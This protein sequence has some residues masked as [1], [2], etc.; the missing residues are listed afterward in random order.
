MVEAE[1]KIRILQS[2]GAMNHGGIEHFVMNLYRAID[3]DKIQFDFMYRV[4]EPCVFDEEI[5]DLGGIIYRCPSPDRHPLR[6][7]KY[8]SAFFAEHPEYKV[9]HE[10]RTANSGFYGL[11][12][13]ARRSC[14]QTRIVHSHSSMSLRRHGTM[15]NM[16]ELA[17][18]RV[19]TPRIGEIATDYIACSDAA[20][21]W[22]FPETVIDRGKVVI[23]PNGIRVDNFAYNRSNRALVRKKFEIP[24]GALVIGHVGRFQKVKNHAFLVELL[25]F[26]I[27]GGN[28]AYLLL[29][30]DGDLRSDIEERALSCGLAD[31]VV[32]AGPQSNPSPFYSAMDVFCMPSLHEGLPVSC[33]E[34]QASGLPLVLSDVISKQ[35]DL[36]GRVDF[37]SL[38]APLSDWGKATL[39]ALRTEEER[40]AGRVEVESAGFDISNQAKWFEKFYTRKYCNRN[41]DGLIIPNN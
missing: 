10:H 17:T 30:G 22:L 27:E 26:L 9:V 4:A 39:G 35:A 40:F 31:N 19:N 16:V 1:N 24:D 32:F 2:V 15:E 25:K 5:R 33:V 29:V 20:A 36:T 6:A 18:I 21:D 23:I 3:R 14:G 41:E 37:L 11:L 12:R 28:A 8:Y 34:A 38:K 13:A 7:H